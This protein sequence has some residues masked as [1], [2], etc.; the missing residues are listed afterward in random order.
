MQ[1]S[2]T[3]APSPWTLSD[4]PTSPSLEGG[5]VLITDP[6][7]KMEEHSQEELIGLTLN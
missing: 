6:E 7:E 2:R 4:S 1:P 3:H 5:G